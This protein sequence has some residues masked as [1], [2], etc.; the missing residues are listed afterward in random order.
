MVLRASDN[1]R[2][3]A[4]LDSFQSLKGLLLLLLG[5]RPTHSKFLLLLTIAMIHQSLTEFQLILAKCFICIF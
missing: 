3:V 1:V 2:D 4:S 5:R